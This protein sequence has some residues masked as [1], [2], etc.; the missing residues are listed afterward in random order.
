MTVAWILTGSL[1][2]FV[3]VYEIKFENYFHLIFTLFSAL[4]AQNTEII[5]HEPI[6]KFDLFNIRKCLI[7]FFNEINDSSMDSDWIIDS[8]CLC[9]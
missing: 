7:K 9:L 3:Y 5:T 6:L 1:I 8:I 4:L 2:Q